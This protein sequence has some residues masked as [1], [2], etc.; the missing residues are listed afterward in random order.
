MAVMVAAVRLLILHHCIPILNQGRQQPILSLAD[1]VM[2]ILAAAE[3][4]AAGATA[5]TEDLMRVVMVAVAVVVAVEGVI[6]FCYY[7]FCSL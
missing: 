6:K 1:L 3:A 7:L 4:A 2:V 5:A